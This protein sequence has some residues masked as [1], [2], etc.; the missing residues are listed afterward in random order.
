MVC[1]HHG[2]W[3]C[4]GW[5]RK[6]ARNSVHRMI[7]Y[8]MERNYQKENISKTLN[9]DVFLCTNP[10]V[11][12]VWNMPTDVILC[13]VKS[14]TMFSSITPL[15]EIFPGSQT[16]CRKPACSGKMENSLRAGDMLVFHQNPS[17]WPE[18]LYPLLWNVTSVR[19]GTCQAAVSP[20]PSTVP[21][22]QLAVGKY[23]INEWILG[24]QKDLLLMLK[25]WVSTVW[26]WKIITPKGNGCVFCK[27]NMNGNNIKNSTY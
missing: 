17:H 16:P 27:H 7:P 25:W 5:M 19:V 2:I 6:Q 23:F 1:P 3:L 8:S 10:Y 21:G 9:I 22:T 4:Y 13:T 18:N 14:R 20:G 24:A 15:R 26:K 12:Y 11:G